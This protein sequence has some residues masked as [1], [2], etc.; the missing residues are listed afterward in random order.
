MMGDYLS[1]SRD[2]SWKNDLAVV[3]VVAIGFIGLVGLGLDGTAMIG[4]GSGIS[5]V[6]AGE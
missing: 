4:P 6:G 3:A 2:D 5:H 1:F